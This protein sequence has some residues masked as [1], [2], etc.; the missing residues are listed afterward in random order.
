VNSSLSKVRSSSLTCDIVLVNF[1]NLLLKVWV[2]LLTQENSKIRY[3][4]V[5]AVKQIS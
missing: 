1:L 3:W 4:Y 2:S 5:G